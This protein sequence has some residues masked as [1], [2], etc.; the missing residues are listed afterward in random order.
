MPDRSGQ[1]LKERPFNPPTSPP[2]SLLPAPPP[3]CQEPASLRTRP[4]PSFGSKYIPPQV[5]RLFL[6]N[7]YPLL[8]VRKAP[9]KRVG[10]VSTGIGIVLARWLIDIFR[11]KSSKK[12][13]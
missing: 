5:C 13:S 8:K 2:T 4:S 9:A 10:T 11:A 6:Q 3:A 12:G 7:R 1:I